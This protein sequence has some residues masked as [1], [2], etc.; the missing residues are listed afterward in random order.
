MRKWLA[1]VLSA[2]HKQSIKHTLV[3]VDE[4]CLFVVARWTYL[5]PLYY[6]CTG[7]FSA[8]QRAGVAGRLAFLRRE[9]HSNALSGFLRRH[10]HRL[11]KGLIM[12][13]RKPLFAR[14]YILET[15]TVFAEGLSL[16]IWSDNDKRWA[17]S[18]LDEY[19]VVV[20]HTDENVSVAF[21]KYKF[22]KKQFDL[23]TFDDV[24]AGSGHA[25]DKEANVDVNTYVN[26]QV[27]THVNTQHNNGAKPYLFTERKTSSV[28]FTE[29]TALYQQRRS[30]R[31]FTDEPVPLSVLQDAITS[32]AQAPSACNRQSFKFISFTEAKDAQRVGAIAAGTT[33]FAH[34]FPCLLVLV[35][36][37]SAYP[38]EKD[39]HVIYIDGALASMQLMLALETL[40]LSSCPINWA[41]EPVGNTKMQAELNLSPYQR[42]LMLLAVGYPDPNGQIAYSAKKDI[43]E[44]LDAR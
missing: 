38:F 2:Q 15:V 34:Q 40:G 43:T 3:R 12:V 30:V 4:L 37:L 22:V 24:I 36:D 39:R 20:E 26:T 28:S 25:S 44:L 18:V 16:G 11:E 23:G 19:F 21:D 6:F 33:G 8:Q 9:H 42:V 7:G 5:V 27:N 1:S 31:W 29:L 10:I 41:D 14:D 32:A 13:P 35:G 17:L